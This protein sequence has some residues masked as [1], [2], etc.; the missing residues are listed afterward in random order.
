[1]AATIIHR[2]DSVIKIAPPGVDPNDIVPNWSIE[3]TT[4]E[5][6]DADYDWLV[7]GNSFSFD[8]T[9]FTQQPAVETNRVLVN[10]QEE[11]DNFIAAY[12]QATNFPEN[13]PD[14]DNALTLIRAL[15][16]D[17]C[18][19]NPSNPID[20]ILAEAGT[21]IRPLISMK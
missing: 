2:G 4:M 15:D 20:T 21:P 6:S 1:M 13:Q 3:A 18:P 12:E 14:A 17:T 8:G 11:I 10:W 16:R 19:A 5:I 9:T 7:Q